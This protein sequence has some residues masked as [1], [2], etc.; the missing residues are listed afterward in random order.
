MHRIGAV[1]GYEHAKKAP[2][3]ERGLQEMDFSQAS[4]TSAT[5][6]LPATM[7]SALTAAGLTALATLLA[8]MLA[9]LAGILRLLAGLLPA[10]LLLT[11]LLVR[12]RIL[13][14]L[15]HSRS[16]KGHAPS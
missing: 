5:A 13:W 1:R 4:E 11:G 7:L 6:L 8:A 3:V 15:A 12:I 9:A 16:S 2:L 10:T 14:I